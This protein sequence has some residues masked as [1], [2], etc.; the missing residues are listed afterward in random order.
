M[1]VV[2]NLFTILF[3]LIIAGCSINKPIEQPKNYAIVAKSPSKTFV[4]KYDSV[5]IDSV[6]ADEPFNDTQM[7]YRLSEYNF[8]S[9]YY[10]RYITEPSAIVGSQLSTWLEKSGIVSKTAPSS[11]GVPANY[12]LKSTI[13]K[14]YGDF[15]EG[16]RS[17]A[18][19]EVQFIFMDRS[20]VKPIILLDKKI[21][22]R[23]EVDNKT[24]EGLAQGLSL[25][26]RDILER[27][28]IELNDLE[29]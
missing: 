24:P 23:I 11:S 6:R 7:V 28:L 17:E 15:R 14:L 4:T 21:S 16:E 3:L 26:F 27:M 22:S 25:A 5:L 29:I 9:D 19:M 8:E 2:N 20:Q 18:V 1:K 10:N 13:T 12:V